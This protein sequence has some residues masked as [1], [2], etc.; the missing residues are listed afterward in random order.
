MTRDLLI[1]A[2]SVAAGY[3]LV[4]F[5]DAYLGLTELAEEIAAWIRAAT[6][7]DPRLVGGG[8]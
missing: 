3:L 6:G 7:L 1:T 2:G 4:R 5:L 8:V